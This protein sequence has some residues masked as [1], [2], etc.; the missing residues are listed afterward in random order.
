[1]TTDLKEAQR[2][3]EEFHVSLILASLDPVLEPSKAQILAGEELLKVKNIFGYLNRSF[4]DSSVVSSNDSSSLVT[5]VGGHGSGRGDGGCGRY[6]GHGGSI[7]GGGR[8][9]RDG[10]RG[11]GRGPPQRCSYCGMNGHTVC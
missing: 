8:G 9:G 10:G 2:Q 11:G 5:S 4:L 7:R 1:M 6:G 3:K